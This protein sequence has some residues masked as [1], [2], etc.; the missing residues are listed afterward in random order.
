MQRGSRRDGISDPVGQLTC[1]G[2][3][4]ACGDDPVTPDPLTHQSVLTAQLGAH[5]TLDTVDGIGQLLAD[6]CRDEAL[7]LVQ[8]GEQHREW[9][10]IAGVPSQGKVHR[11]QPRV[12][13]D[14]VDVVDQERRFAGFRARAGNRRVQRDALLQSGRGDRR[15]YEGEPF[16]QVAD[17]SRI[18]IRRQ[19]GTQHPPG[20]GAQR[21]D[22]G[23]GVSRIPSTRQ[24]AGAT[25]Q[26]EAIAAGP[27]AI[28]GDVI[29]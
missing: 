17:Q 27:Q 4:Q 9:R 25:G 12:P 14:A 24:G 10:G 3:L 26:G 28:Q 19:R 6:L 2:P 8:V 20:D 16:S 11:P 18:G 21:I 23:G 5:S 29:A 13:F 22:G 7:D 15:T 1:L